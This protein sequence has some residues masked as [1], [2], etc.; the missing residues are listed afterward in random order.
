MKNKFTLLLGI[1]S[2]IFIYSFN[3]RNDRTPIQYYLGDQSKLEVF[4]KTNVNEFCCAS[5]EKFKPQKLT[6]EIPFDSDKMKFNRAKLNIQINEMD[7]GGRLINKD[8]RRTLNADKCPFISI[9]LKEIIN[10]DC[11]NL[12]ECDNWIFFIA[13]TE[14]TI[15]EVNQKINIP[16][17]ILKETDQKFRVTGQKKLQLSDFKIIPPTAFMG[18]I[19]VRNSIEINFDLEV[20][21]I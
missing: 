8:F 13:S 6:Y 16:I 10:Q 18:M 20:I 15:N 21:L 4:G 3:L 1:L 12:R 7:C 5:Y 14:I 9:D 11:D 2:L 19:K 17:H